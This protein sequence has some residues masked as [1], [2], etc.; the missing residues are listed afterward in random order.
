MEKV[1][2]HRT[3][4]YSEYFYILFYYTECTARTRY[5]GKVGN[6]ESCFIIKLNL[7][8][9]QI[10]VYFSIIFKSVIVSSVCPLRNNNVANSA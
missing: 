7:D 8:E 9:H 10:K 1:G 6:S 5:I 4:R 3:F 2:K